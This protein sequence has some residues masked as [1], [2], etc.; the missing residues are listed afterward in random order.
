VTALPVFPIAR[1]LVPSVTKTAPPDLTDTTFDLTAGVPATF[2][3]TTDLSLTVVVPTGQ[4]QTVLDA[5]G[6]TVASSDVP[7][8]AAS[9][10]AVDT[11]G[12]VARLPARV[13]LQ[14]AGTV[15]ASLPLV[16]GLRCVFPDDGGDVGAAV[17]VEVLEWTLAAGT[18]AGPGGFGSTLRIA[19]RTVGKGSDMFQPPAIDPNIVTRLLD[20]R[21]A[22]STLGPAVKRAS[23]GYAPTPIVVDVVDIGLTYVDWFDDIAYSIAY[24]SWDW[25]IS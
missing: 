7:Q 23:G 11:V 15:L 5:D 13:V 10:G 19:W 17:E 1:M 2:Q 6:A 25:G 22:Q 16:A 8:R 9:D 4:V 24:D 21:Q 14:R 12:S 18:L 20:P 3:L